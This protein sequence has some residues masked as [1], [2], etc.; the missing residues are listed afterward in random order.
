MN[1][2]PS[3]FQAIAAVSK[4]ASIRLS[5]RPVGLVLGL[6]LLAWG[7]AAGCGP[8][9]P[10]AEGAGQA[11]R[12]LRLG[13]GAEPKSLDPHLVTGVAEHNVLMALLEGLVSE[14]P[15]TLEPVPGV[16]ERWEV[17]EDGCTYTFHLRDSARWSNGDPVLAADF[18]FSFRR[19]LAPALAAEYA[20]MLYPLKNARAYNTGALADPALVGA[21]ASAE[22]T[23]VLTLEHPTPYFLQLL[24]H[25]SWLPVHPGTIERHGRIDQRHTP[26]TRPEHWVGNGPFTLERWDINR[27]LSVRP[28]P[29]YWDA[30]TVQLDGIDFL[31]IDSA[32]TEERAFREG[33]LHVTNTVPLHRL[34][35]YRRLDP[36]PL[37]VDPYLG[38]YFYRFNTRV[39]PL[40][41]ARVRRALSLCIEREQ[42]TAF[43]LR[44]GQS[45][46]LHITPPNTGG[47]TSPARL[48]G[49]AAAA[50]RLLAEAGYPDG[51][52][53]PPLE[54]LYNT[55]EQHRVLAEAVQQMWKSALGVDVTLVNQEWK[56]SLDSLTRGDYQIARGS[57][58][59]DYNDPN[60]FLDLW[61]TDG[62]N[63][64][65]GWSSPDYDRAVEAAAQTA[66]TARRHE[67]FGQAEAILI[68]EM[69]VAPVYF[70]V[71]TMLIQPSVQGWFPTLLDH[72]PYK[73]V[74]L[75]AAP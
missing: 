22:R 30:A 10:G 64:R 8:A 15:R 71:R 43:V 66:D 19:M 45:P 3:G 70:Y 36:S 29:H 16:A 23:L 49:D 17:A 75:T 9:R 27:V 42:L 39:K 54:L 68:D 50:R 61:M 20:Y 63:N 44:G 13:N 25:T 51:K 58:I 69:P 32:D 26:W 56:V 59:G 2:H 31:P 21:V 46:A 52:G 74:R 4:A 72:H 55:S 48:S 38:V 24:N 67:L 40:D 28:N 37:R 14:D 47:C 33:K 53:F 65:T 35:H 60:S 1:R 12:I 7:L 62:G 34:D 41:D 5:R 18:V 6:A 11:S 57:W 73:H